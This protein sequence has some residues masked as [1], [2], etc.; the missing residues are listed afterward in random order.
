MI[1]ESSYASFY[2]TSEPDGNGKTFWY[3]NVNETF[4]FEELEESE[5]ERLVVLNLEG[6]NFFKYIDVEIV[7]VNDNR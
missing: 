1:R 7:D 5:K 3:F 2:V 4:D 6:E